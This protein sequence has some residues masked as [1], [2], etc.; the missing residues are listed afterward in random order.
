MIKDMN[1]TI[2]KIGELMSEFEA[3]QNGAM[4]NPRTGKILRDQNDKIIY[5]NN[6]KEEK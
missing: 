6:Q 5:Y 3:I 4:V 1:K 2:D